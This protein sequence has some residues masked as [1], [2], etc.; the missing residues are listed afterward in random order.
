M[1]IIPSKLM[2]GS[3]LKDA[4]IGAVGMFVAPST[5]EDG[6]AEAAY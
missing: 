1:P 5:A 6:E 2:L 3:W 4:S